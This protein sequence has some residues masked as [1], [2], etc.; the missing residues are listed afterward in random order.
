MRVTPFFPTWYTRLKIAKIQKLLFLSNKLCCHLRIMAKV[1][2]SLSL[3]YFHFIELVGYAYYYFSWYLGNL[4]SLFPQIFFLLLFFFLGT[5]TVHTLVLS[6][7][8]SDLFSF[9][10]MFYFLSVFQTRKF[11]LTHF[12]GH[13]FFHLSHHAVQP[14]Y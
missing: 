9:F 5:T 6:R 8:S 13:W 3:S 2:L 11:H 10:F 7:Y 4:G 1:P 14:L 12:Q